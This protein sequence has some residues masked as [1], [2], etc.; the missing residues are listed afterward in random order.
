MKDPLAEVGICL[1]GDRNIV[2]EP[3]EFFKDKM[4]TSLAVEYGLGYGINDKFAIPVIKKGL[5]RGKTFWGLFHH[6]PNY[7][8]RAPYSDEALCWASVLKKL[9]YERKDSILYPSEGYW[10]AFWQ[11]ILTGEISDLIKKNNPDPLA[12][13]GG[14]SEGTYYINAFKFHYEEEIIVKAKEVMDWVNS[15]PIPESDL[16]IW[17]ENKKELFGTGIYE[18]MPLIIVSV[19]PKTR[20][21]IAGDDEN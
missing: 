15:D 5:N 2:T 4:N 21:E 11:I 1:F 17:I 7:C 3:K 8:E 16:R 14:E 12:F 9:N 18:A 6:N 10:K 13:V 19:Q 20:K